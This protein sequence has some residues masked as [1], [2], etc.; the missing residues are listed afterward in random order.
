M[1]A[2]Q[3]KD[4]GSQPW[5]AKY[6]AP[7]HQPGSVTREAVLD[8]LQSDSLVAGRDYLLVD[9]RRNDHEVRDSYVGL[10]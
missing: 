5:H 7:Q 8:M 10:V 6:P 1:A 3:P 2:E 4:A 9:V